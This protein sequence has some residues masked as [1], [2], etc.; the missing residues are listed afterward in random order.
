[1]E[2][3]HK[4]LTQDK[5]SEIYLLHA[6]GKSRGQIA[7]I[8]GVHK[9]TISR[10]LKRNKDPD[11]G[12]YLPD[13]AQILAQQRRNRPGLKIERSKT[14]QAKIIDHIAMGWSPE[15]VAGRLKTE[16]VE[17]RI[18]HESIYKWIYG[19]GKN[20]NLIQYLV[21]KKRKRG[22]RPCR[23]AKATLIPDRLSIH[24]RPKEFLKEFGHWEGDTVIFAGG[25]GALVTLYERIS[26]VVL[27][28]KVPQKKADIVEEA[29]QNIL[30]DLPEESRKSI[31]FDNGG[32]FA[33]HMSLRE[34]LVDKTYFCDPY[35]SWQKGGVENANGIIRRDVPKGSKGKDYTDSDIQ[36]IIDDINNT[37]RKSLGFL[38]PIE[39]FNGLVTGKKPS[40]SK[41]FDQ[42]DC[43]QTA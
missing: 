33:R 31:T 39:K 1:M 18:S 42:V 10:E 12:V 25:K 11:V 13:K 24:E 23:K 3:K 30:E 19:I 29:L 15:V 5:R 14:L 40:L 4:H 41:I 17:H 28:K 8:L 20:H 27:A 21:R 22:T 26:K 2:K 34:F 32:E 37:P 36:L 43:G 16:G 35:S 9:S 6:G 38:T 7:Q